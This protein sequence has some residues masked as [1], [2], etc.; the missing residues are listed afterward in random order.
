MRGPRKEYQ[1][2]HS[3]LMPDRSFAV[4]E[5]KM[6]SGLSNGTTRASAYN[7]AARNVAC[8]AEALRRAE[9]SAEDIPTL[10]FFVLAPR[11]QIDAGV[12]AGLLDKGSLKSVVE[13]RTATYDPPKTDWFVDFF[14]P[15][16]DA[17][18]VS[19]LAWEDVVDVIKS[20]DP[21]FGDHI[22]TFY[23]HCLLFNRAE[24]ISGWRPL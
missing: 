16:L 15:T 5:A 13:E 21:P 6:F 4:V 17:I 19:A 2:Y 18:R 10:G 14:L 23:Q 20:V 22:E 9:V 7:Q 12:F 8:M 11:E 24:R 1:G 3:S